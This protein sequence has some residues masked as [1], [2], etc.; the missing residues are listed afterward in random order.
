M[1]W[2]TPAE[3]YSA[4][5]TSQSIEITSWRAV[6]IRLNPLNLLRNQ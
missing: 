2:P 1:R 5:T 3:V 4:S 6:Y